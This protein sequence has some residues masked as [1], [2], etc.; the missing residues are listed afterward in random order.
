MEFDSSG[1][2]ISD[3]EMTI[4]INGL[5]GSAD[6]S[7]TLSLA[8]STQ[9]NMGKEVGSIKT[10]VV[11]GYAAGDLVGYSISDVRSNCHG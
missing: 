10:P 2:L 3:P 4:N 11:D 1:K 9:Q 6:N 7:F 5:N 8:N